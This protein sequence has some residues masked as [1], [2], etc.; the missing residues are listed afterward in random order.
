MASAIIVALWSASRKKKLVALVDPTQ[1]IPL[2]LVEK[3]ELSHDTR[4]FRFGLPSKKHCLGKM[5]T[6]L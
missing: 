6:H 4:R 2:P 3:E 1:K 5:V